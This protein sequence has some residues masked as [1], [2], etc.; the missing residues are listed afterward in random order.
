[1]D[2]KLTKIQQMR[3][4]DQQTLATGQETI[5]T[6]QDHT[7]SNTSKLNLEDSIQNSVGD[8]REK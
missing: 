4:I 6:N 7:D 5:F 2:L 3:D 1:M 8:S